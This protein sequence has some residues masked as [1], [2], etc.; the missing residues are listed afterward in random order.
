MGL[1]IVMVANAAGDI[2]HI[3]VIVAVL[4]R[5]LGQLAQFVIAFP[6]FIHGVQQFVHGA[7]FV[8]KYKLFYGSQA[9]GG[10][11]QPD[12]GQ[13]RPD[14]VLGAAVHQV[15]AFFQAGFGHCREEWAGDQHLLQFLGQNRAGHGNGDQVVKLFHESLFHFLIGSELPVRMDG[16]AHLFA[17]D[18]ALA[19]VGGIFKSA[20]EVYVYGAG[21]FKGL[22]EMGHH[23][24]AVV[25]VP[26]VF[27]FI[28]HVLQHLV[29][30]LVAVDGREARSLGHQ[31]HDRF[32]KFMG[33]VMTDADRKAGLVC[34][35]FPGR[36]QAQVAQFVGSVLAVPVRAAYGQ[37]LE[38]VVAGKEIR[39]VGG[40]R[41]YPFGQLQPVTFNQFQDAVFVM[42]FV[43]DIIFIIGIHIL[44]KPA[45][46]QGQGVFHQDAAQ[47]VEPDHLQGFLE[48]HGRLRRDTA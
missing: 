8:I 13:H 36:L 35:H 43:F 46:V 45:R 22:A 5:I 15:H 10:F 32:H 27:R 18:A 16:Q 39:R 28:A 40:N 17:G 6:V 24:A 25:P 26:G 33:A 3:V 29:T 4:G 38:L 19:A 30:G 48:G 12:A 47:L 37:V 42:Q 23:A 14:G 9:V 21:P 1:F 34:L 31:F 41:P 20:A 44:V 7:Y 2:V 11:R